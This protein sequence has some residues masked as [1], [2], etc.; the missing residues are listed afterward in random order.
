V[1]R[2]ELVL[3]VS[4]YTRDHCTTQLGRA[5]PELVVCPKQ[6]FKPEPLSAWPAPSALLERSA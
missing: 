3:P 1:Q 5:W 2:L 4:R 6:A